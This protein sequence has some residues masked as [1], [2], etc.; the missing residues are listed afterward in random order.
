MSP[1][2]ERVRYHH[3]DRLR[4]LAVLLLFPFHVARVFNV[5]ED[6]YVK[7]PSESPILSWA[8]VHILD[9]WHM[10][11]LFVLAG[12]ATWFALGHRTPGAYVG[13]R[14]RRLL[15][16]LLFGLVFVV[17]PQAWLAQLRFEDA[18]RSPLAFLAG[19]VTNPTDGS[20][21]DGGLTPG[22]LWFVLYLFVFSLVA[23]PLFARVRR[24][25]LGRDVGRRWMLGTAVF[26]MVLAEALPA[27]EG[28]KSPWTSFA[29]FAFGFALASSPA[30]LGEIERRWRPILAAAVG[31][32]AGVFAV[33]AVIGDPAEHGA[34]ADGVFQVLESTNTWLWVLGLIGAAATFLAGPP[35]PLLRIANEAAYPVY[36]LHQTV[37]VALAYVVVGW[38]LGVVVAYPL[39][40][41]VSLAVT[42]L[43]YDVLVRRT[44]VTRFLFG[45]KPLSER[46]P[47]LR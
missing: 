15:V 41:A 32:M 34:L 33:W 30:L 7:H 13:E 19:Y 44:N 29:Q 43:A 37:I 26:V 4:I 31:T 8:V 45:L 47:A 18:E 16:P 27:P 3:L 17:P 5:G 28:G 21:Y 24:V 11:L 20:G 2:A 12:M 46:E 42:F 14:V 35:T 25:A 40:L 1:P 38:D 22:H 36:V 10:P 23:I 6:W 39:L 9:P